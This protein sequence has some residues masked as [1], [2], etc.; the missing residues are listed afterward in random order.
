MCSTYCDNKELKKLILNSR[1]TKDGLFSHE[2][3]MISYAAIGQ[4]NALNPSFSGVF[5]VKLKVAYPI[6]LLM[7][8][9][10]RGYI[11]CQ[12]SIDYLRF[13]RTS[14]LQ[15]F[16]K[17]RG[18]KR[19]NSRD[20]MVKIITE[21]CSETEINNE[22]PLSFFLPTDAGLAA[23]E[24][25]Q[26]DYSTAYLGWDIDAKHFGGTPLK[27]SQLKMFQANVEKIEVHVSEAQE[28]RYYCVVAGLKSPI[29]S[30][31]LVLPKR[32]SLTIRKNDKVIYSIR[33]VDAIDFNYQQKTIVFRTLEN[34]K[35]RRMTPALLVCLNL[36]SE[37]VD[38]R[39]FDEGGQHE[40]TDSFEIFVQSKSHTKYSIKQ[41]NHVFYFVSLNDRLA[42]L[43]LSSFKTPGFKA[44]EILELE[45]YLDDQTYNV[46]I[47]VPEKDQLSRNLIQY[48][49]SEKRLG[50]VSVFGTTIREI[51]YCLYCQ[52]IMN[53]TQSKSKYEFYHEDILRHQEC[54]DLIAILKKSDTG[55][56]RLQS[57]IWDFPQSLFKYDV[58]RYYDSSS[59]YSNDENWLYAKD[60]QS[61][62]YRETCSRTLALR[63][64]GII[65]TRWIN[66]FNLYLIVKNI[67]PDCI[68]QY[69]T[70]WLKQ[71]SLDI[72]IPSKRVGIE[73]QG[74][75]HYEAVEI[76]GGEKGLLATQERDKRKALACKENNVR[77]IEWNYTVEVTENNVMSLLKRE[78]IEAS[79]ESVGSM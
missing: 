7:S 78:K 77:L 20:K 47:V 41:N 17:R 73:Y 35:V 11:S 39:V 14:Q 2:L 51:A 70:G 60:H 37:E 72:Y 53:Q 67:F 34:P 8:M 19:P 21:A 26:Y 38:Y 6:H 36:V 55:L 69:R 75:Q 25:A 12:Y 79:L 24:N 30:T 58:Y 33:D 63:E 15:A 74:A 32:S 49:I 52:D 23:L 10:E 27:S 5:Q 59:Q 31:V 18:F 54:L 56:E 66:E 22:L 46:M 57:F 42:N 45:K 61:E 1:P 64:Q 28:W 43:L 3:A 65:P 76:F 13:Y 16:A 50:E 68:Y 71:Q 4:I 44:V 29:F 40:L 48:L 9:I 62:L